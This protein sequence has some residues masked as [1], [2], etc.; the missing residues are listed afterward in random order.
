MMDEHVATT[1][2]GKHVGWA[3]RL[4]L[5]QVRVRDGQEVRV[6]QIVAVDIGQREQAGQ[7]Q[8]GRQP[9]DLLVPD[10]KFTGE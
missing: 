2:R 10:V 6:G 8:R 5:G 3:S 9:E 4:H 1:N 7:V